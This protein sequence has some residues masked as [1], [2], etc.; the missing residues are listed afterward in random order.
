MQAEKLETVR[1]GYAKRWFVVAS[2][3]CV[4]A[5]VSALYLAIA[6]LEDFT[7]TFWLIVVVSV[8]ALLLLFPLP[9]VFTYHTAG[10]RF[11]RLHMGLIMKID[12]PYLAIREVSRKD[13]AK[14]FLGVGLGVRFKD[15]SGAVYVVSSFD[16]AVSINLKEELKLRAWRPSVYE[17]VISVKDDDEVLDL[18]SRRISPPGG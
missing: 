10:E 17:I 2:A 8:T 3:A 7:T 4:V 1:I 18:L 12:I 9:C 15:R 14:G 6:S 5:I 13:I 11:L 16:K